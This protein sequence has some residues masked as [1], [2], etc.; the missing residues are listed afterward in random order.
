MIGTV[1]EAK[2]KAKTDLA[3]DP[4]KSESAVVAAVDTDES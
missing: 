2:E 3:Q 4:A 1:D